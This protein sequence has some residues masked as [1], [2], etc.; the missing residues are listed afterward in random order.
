[1]RNRRNEMKSPANKT[2]PLYRSSLTPVAPPNAATT[3]GREEEAGKSPPAADRKRNELV[4]K[5]EKSFWRS[6]FSFG[7]SYDSDSDSDDDKRKKNKF[8]ENN[9][10]RDDGPKLA[11]RKSSADRHT[12][13]NCPTEEEA[14][15]ARH[16][17][18]HSTRTVR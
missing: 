12:N 14:K 7:S 13:F 2:K 4:H 1:M 15:L 17:S 10:N 6:W 8:N 5:E 18:P 3:I 9:S 11:T 16:T